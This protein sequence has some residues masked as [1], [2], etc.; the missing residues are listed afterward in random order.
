MGPAGGRRLSA[1]LGTG[2]FT[3]A[4]RTSPADWLDVSS[5]NLTDLEYR[6]AGCPA[7]L[8]HACPAVGEAKY[9][10]AGGRAYVYTY[11]RLCRAAHV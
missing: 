7:N 2:S 3:D 10:T 4:N 11:G 8:A 5:G 1:L 6:V 9:F